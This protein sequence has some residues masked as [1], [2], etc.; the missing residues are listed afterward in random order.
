MKKRD[1]ASLGKSLRLAEKK[2]TKGL[3]KWRFKRTGLP[4][5]DEEAM[6]RGSEQI[7]DEAHKIVKRRAGRIVGEFKQAKEAFLKAYRDE[8]E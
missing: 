1:D 4:T 3:L 5:P 8:E 7:V 6:N 2:L